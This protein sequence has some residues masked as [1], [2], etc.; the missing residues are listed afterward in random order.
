[1]DMIVPAY[2]IYPRVIS[3]LLQIEHDPVYPEFIF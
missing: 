1:M 3:G 2:F